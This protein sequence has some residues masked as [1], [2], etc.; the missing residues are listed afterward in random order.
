MKITK[1]TRSQRVSGR[2]YL[3]FEG[4]GSLRVTDAQVADYSLYTGRELDGDEYQSLTE[5]AGVS[6]ARARALRILGT[7]GMSR[8]A[9]IDRLAEKGEDADTARETADWLEKIGMLDDAEYARAVARH[10]AARG[11]G[12][13]RIRDEFFKRKVAR[14]MWDAALAEL[15]EDGGALS[16]LIESKLRGEQ[17]DRAGQK[18][19]T[20]ALIRRGYSWDEVSAAMRRYLDNADR[21]GEY[22]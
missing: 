17:P 15:P 1:M 3:D 8:Q 13:R 11:Y 21:N 4:G 19:V 12:T 22:D 14:D 10:Y 7:R 2:V 20:D 6:S 18:R 9:L 16:A 5:A